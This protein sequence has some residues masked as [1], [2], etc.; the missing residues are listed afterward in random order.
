MLLTF[1]LKK[2]FYKRSCL[3]SRW[4]RSLEQPQ[5]G[6]YLVPNPK[7]DRHIFI[8]RYTRFLYDFYISSQI[9][10][11]GLFYNGISLMIIIWFYAT[12]TI[13]VRFIWFNYKQTLWRHLLMSKHLFVNWFLFNIWDH[14]AKCFVWG[15]FMKA[16]QAQ[17]S[18]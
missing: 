2:V 11:T 9:L 1:A 14:L 6:I 16:N 7:S 13:T 12:V 10:F 5:S 18:E 8:T 17:L 15:L 3:H 4:I